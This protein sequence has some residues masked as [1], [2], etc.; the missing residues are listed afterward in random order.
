[1]SRSRKQGRT[2]GGQCF[3]TF[4]IEA[5]VASPGRGNDVGKVLEQHLSLNSEVVGGEAGCG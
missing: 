5:E 2:P 1:M 4:D 3:M